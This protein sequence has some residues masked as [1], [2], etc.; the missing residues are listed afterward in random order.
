MGRV[1]WITSVVA[2]AVVIYGLNEGV[3]LSEK[4][5]VTQ[6]AQTDAVSDGGSSHSATP[7]IGDAAKLLTIGQSGSALA[8]AAFGMSAL[9]PETYDGDMVASIIAASPLEELEKV[10]LTSNLLE[11]EKGDADLNHVL[12][13][14]RSALAVD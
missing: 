9:Q 12:S 10:E 5:P 6:L 13:E 8:T 14:V 3:R 2:A 11:A 1:F 4:T 7:D